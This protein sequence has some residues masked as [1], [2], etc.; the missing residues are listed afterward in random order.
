MKLE[1]LK[2]NVE[3]K[4]DDTVHFI[5]SSEMREIPFLGAPY[6][7]KEIIEHELIKNKVYKTG[8]K[9]MIVEINFNT[10]TLSS[11]LEISKRINMN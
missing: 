3:L 7:S 2:I 1:D 4:S 10:K 11:L 9:S 8:D 6:D 5:P